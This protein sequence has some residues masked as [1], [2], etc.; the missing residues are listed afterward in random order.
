MSF[1]SK[2]FGGSGTQALDPGAAAAPFTLS[3]AEG[4]SYSLPEALK[5]GPVLLAFFKV[6]CPTCQFTLPF[7][8]RLHQAIKGSGAARLWGVSQNDA[9][10]TRAFAE[11]Y[12]LSFPMLLDD[13]GYPVS[14]G[15][16]LTNVPTLF[17][18]EPN[19]AIRISSI[20]FSRKDIED[21][22]AE[23][24]KRTSL[25]ISVF[26]PGERIPDSKAG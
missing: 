26:Q 13:A 23:F 16:G 14:N 15:Y 22:A 8:E 11:E 4:K 24:G 25:P 12:G 19:G 9:G 2:L 3:D 17:L 10:Q 5:Q 20:G 6:S 1:F 21:I 7:L 18:I